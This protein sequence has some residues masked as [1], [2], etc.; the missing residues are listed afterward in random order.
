M[1]STA[2]AD[3][4]T[5]SF[6]LKVDVLVGPESKLIYYEAT[7]QHVRHYIYITRGDNTVS[8]AQCSSSRSGS[9]ALSY[10]N[11]VITPGWQLMSAGYRTCFHTL[12]DEKKLHKV[13]DYIIIYDM[14]Y[15]TII[16][17]IYIYIYIYCTV[18]YTDLCLYLYTN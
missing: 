16:F 10:R 6:S 17:Y 4:A 9:T 11:C 18:I 13:Y 14:I 2:P 12:Y 1:Y 3:W 5:H 15:I 8:V 7:N